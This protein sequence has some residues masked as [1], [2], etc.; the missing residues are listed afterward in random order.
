MSK[1]LSLALIPVVSSLMVAAQGKDRNLLSGFEAVS[2]YEVRAGVLAIPR[3]ASDGQICEIGLQPL[4]YSP[5]GTR[6]NTKFTPDIINEIFDELVPAEERGPR[7][8]NLLEKGAIDFQGQSMTTDEE[9]EN[10]SIHIYSTVT[11]SGDV[12]RP[13]TYQF[14]ETDVLATLSW[15]HRKCK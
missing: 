10:V 6:L 7:P 8:Q 12:S 14:N 1:L 4:F 11:N 15:K 9:Y 3:F 5:E 2:G 13:S